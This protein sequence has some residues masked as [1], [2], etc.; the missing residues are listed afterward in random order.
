MI[1]S[2]SFSAE[3]IFFFALARFASGVAIERLRM[4]LRFGLATAGDSGDADDG[5]DVDDDVVVDNDELADD[6]E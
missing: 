4:I 2:F 3:L 5:D 1:E 6:G